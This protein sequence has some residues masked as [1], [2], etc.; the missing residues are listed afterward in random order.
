MNHVQQAFANA[1]HREKQLNGKTYSLQLLPASVGLATFFDLIEL[2][3]TSIANI[4]DSVRNEDAMLP[5]EMLTFTHATQLFISNMGNKD[6]MA[7]IHT[8]VSKV[9]CNGQPIDFDSHFAGK[10]GE[11]AIIIE[12]VLKENFKDAFTSWLRDKGL[13][14]P[15]LSNLMKPKET[16]SETSSE[17]SNENLT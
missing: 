15:S 11:L 2:F 3:G 5:E 10:Y 9:S 8:L 17:E 14:I 12:W 6:M 13:E 16:P 1:G 4:A 7:L